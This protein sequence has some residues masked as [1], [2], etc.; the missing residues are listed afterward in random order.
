MTRPVGS[1]LS[2]VPISST[3][4]VNMQFF[5]SFRHFSVGTNLSDN[6]KGCGPTDSLK[7]TPESIMRILPAFW[8]ARLYGPF[9]PLLERTR[10][11]AGCGP[12]LVVDSPHTSRQK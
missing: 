3:M 7:P 2:R 8:P 12:L 6:L 5:L 10:D 4:P 9:L 11:L 1:M